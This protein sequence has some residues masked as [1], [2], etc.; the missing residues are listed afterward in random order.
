MHKLWWGIGEDGKP[1]TKTTELEAPHCEELLPSGE[2]YFS[3][4]EPTSSNSGDFL[5]MYRGKW[6]CPRLEDVS[7]HG[8]WSST[9][10]Q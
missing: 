3:M 10:G 9:E 8:D 6:R 5:T 7:I 2:E 1:V 4:I